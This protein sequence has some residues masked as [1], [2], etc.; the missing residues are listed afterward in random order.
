M[1]VLELELIVA[2]EPQPKSASCLGV[3][4]AERESAQEHDTDQLV[5]V[6]LMHGSSPFHSSANDLFICS[7]RERLESLLQELD[8]AQRVGR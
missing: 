5:K 7:C 2:Q 8:Q 1:V 6:T 3:K 4:C